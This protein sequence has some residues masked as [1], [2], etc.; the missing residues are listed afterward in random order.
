MYDQVRA[1]TALNINPTEAP[2]KGSKM[3]IVMDMSVRNA[4]KNTTSGGG[5]GAIR[6]TDN[7]SHS[8]AVSPH[9]ERSLNSTLN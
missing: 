4:T 7:I 2:S 3:R 5:G 9:N 8:T 6:F 1:Q